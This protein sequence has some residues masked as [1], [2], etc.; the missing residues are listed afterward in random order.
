MIIHPEQVKW[1]KDGEDGKEMEKMKLNNPTERRKFT[2]EKEQLL[3]D[4]QIK[5]KDD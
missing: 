3:A 1:R 2:T 5:Q 4:G